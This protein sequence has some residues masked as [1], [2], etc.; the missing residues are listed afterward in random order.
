REFWIRA[1]NRLKAHPTPPGCPKYGYLLECRGAPVGV[2][3]LISSAIDANGNT[4]I[5]CN[6][7]SWYVE[8][9]FRSYAAMLVS[10]ALK[11]KHVTYFNITPNR[12]TLPI[13]EAQGYV[14]Y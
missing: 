4:R 10:H 14:R 3:L 2:L 5:R 7:S 1:L 11:Y 13:L 8:P 6:V 12:S 9:A